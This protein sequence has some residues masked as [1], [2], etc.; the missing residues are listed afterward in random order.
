ML[1]WY[2]AVLGWVIHLLKVLRSY[3]F[4]CMQ[5]KNTVCLAHTS[6]FDEGHSDAKKTSPEKSGFKFRVLNGTTVT[7]PP[8]TRPPK[9][10]PPTTC[11]IPT[12]PLTT[13]LPTTRPPTTCPLVRLG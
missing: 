5:K 12:C 2:I 11:P 1:H 9:T 13:R 3:T 10:R 7:C 6:S 8:T 4:A